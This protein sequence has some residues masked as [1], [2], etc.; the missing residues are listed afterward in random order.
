MPRQLL[1]GTPAR[2]SRYVIPT[3]GGQL[4]KWS[5]I[6]AGGALTAW[7]LLVLLGVQRVASPGEV[8]AGHATIDTRCAQCHQPAQAVADVRCERCHDPL[9]ARRFAAPAHAVVAAGAWRGTHVE[10]IACAVC[11]AEHRGRAFALQQ[12]GDQRCVSCHEFSSFRSHPEIAAV[13][14][15]RQADPG[16]EF[17]HEIHL[18]EIAK[19]GG[20]RCQSCHE[21]TSDQREFEP[22]A[23]DAHCATCHLKDRVLTLNGIDV[24]RSGWTPANLLPPGTPDLPAPA[25]TAADERGRVMLEAVG[26]RDRWVLA[27]ADRLTRMMPAPVLSLERAKLDDQLPRLAA[28][29]EAVP[30]A[31]LADEELDRWAATLAAEL[32]ALDRQIAAG[33]SPASDAAALATVAVAVD[34]TLLPMVAA[35]RGAPLPASPAPQAPA[36]DAQQLEERRREIGTL[37]DA[38]AA[39]STGPLAERAADLGRRIAALTPDAAGAS[40]VDV[41]ALADRVNA[42]GGALRAVEAA[43]GGALAADIQALRQLVNQ[44]LGSGVDPGAR[45]AGRRD[46]MTMIDAI[47][48]RA[49]APLRARIAELRS[50]V[51]TLADGAEEPLKSRRDQKARLLDRI[52]IER[53]LRRAHGRAAVDTVAQGERTTAAREMTARRARAAVLESQIAAQPEDA[54]A[55]TALKGLLDACLRCHRLN[56]DETA[57]RPVKAGHP[58]LTASTF[59][60]RPHLL[61]ERCESCH[62]TV[63]T[64]KMGVDANV[65]S[66]AKCQSCHNAS[67]A[68]P[69]CITCHVYHPRSA[70]ELALAAWR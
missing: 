66:V 54:R 32:D 69:A 4:V 11:H 37:V 15:G 64:S 48:A 52:D 70:A 16:V 8:A 33:P 3:S 14:A 10:P 53:T 25:M 35:L 1:P 56:D 24:L 39:R 12:V 5:L 59:S 60:H 18:R 51:L 34:P 17:S 22:I 43:T 58:L 28:V 44:R 41:P 68:S 7:V 57:L 47:S 2:S 55:G 40:V 38:V 26:H 31:A 20:D 21:P 27:A 29:A 67:Q 36:S 50:A 49:D 42:V 9:D 46:L 19:T 62:S 65:P 23:F 63:T 6:G 45:A 61:Q 13:R 30:V